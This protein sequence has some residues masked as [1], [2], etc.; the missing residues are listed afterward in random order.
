MRCQTSF[1]W[2]PAFPAS[3]LSTWL[4]LGLSTWW[5]LGCLWNLFVWCTFLLLV[6]LFLRCLCYVFIIYT[7]ILYKSL[8][9]LERIY[10]TRLSIRHRVI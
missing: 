2:A 3:A 10:Q 6:P 9:A 7:Y 5:W 1:L 8:H 4:W